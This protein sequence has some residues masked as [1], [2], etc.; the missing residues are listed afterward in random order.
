MTNILLNRMLF[1]LEI[2]G[3]GF[4]FTCRLRKKRYFWLRFF[5]CM[6]FCMAFSALFGSLGSN[7]WATSLIFFAIF[8]L[9]V[10]L[11][12]LC[13]DEPWQNLIFCGIAAYTTQHFTYEFANLV[14]SSVTNG[15]SPLLGTYGTE[16]IEFS[17]RNWNWL[18]FYASVYI[19]CGYVS[20]CGAFF[21]F[22]RQIKN[23][24]DLKIKNFKLLLLVGVGLVVDILLNAFFVHSDFMRAE[25]EIVLPVSIMIYIYNC[26]CC[27]LLLTVQFGLVLQ[28][29]LEHELDLAKSLS[30]LKAE[31]YEMTKENIDMINQKCHDI[32]HQIR[33]IGYDKR[34]PQDIVDEIEHSVKLYDAVVKTGNE[35]LD[36][37]L[38]DKSLK[39]VANNISLS[40]VADGAKISF[41]KESDLY[42]LFGNALD[43]AIEAVIKVEEKEKR[44]IGLVMYERNGFITLSITNTFVGEV[45]LVDGLPVTTKQNRHIHGYGVKSIQLIVEHYGGEMSVSIQGDVFSLGILIPVPAERRGETDRGKIG[46]ETEKSTE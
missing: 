9:C 31:Q 16:I 17:S 35:V 8:I 36:T 24:N 28:R 39:C 30:R 38:T 22:S 32:K 11:F 43:N 5:G 18:C 20:Y 3:A 19:L 13:F 7:A 40:C 33:R 45:S 6:L 25:S 14:L 26:L 29:R 12:K 21:V 27:I 4:I 46:A 34:L 23:E 10:G 41:V 37:I 42:A 15:V 1:V 2:W 44:I